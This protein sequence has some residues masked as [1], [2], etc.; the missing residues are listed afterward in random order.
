MLS[1]QDSGK[2]QL[3]ERNFDIVVNQITTN[4]DQLPQVSRQSIVFGHVM[5]S[6]QAP[7]TTSQAMTMYISLWCLRLPRP[8][9]L[10]KSAASTAFIFATKK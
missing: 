1:K 3:Q 7:F 8:R 9:A 2:K 10:S 6:I 4:G 5:R